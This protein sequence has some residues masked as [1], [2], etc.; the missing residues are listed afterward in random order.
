MNLGYLWSLVYACDMFSV[1]KDKGIHDKETGEKLRREVLE[2][3]AIY[4]GTQMPILVFQCSY[5]ARNGYAC[6]VSRTTARSARLFARRRGTALS[7]MGGASR[8]SLRI[9]EQISFVILRIMSTAPSC[10]GPLIRS[11]ANSD[12]GRTKDSPSHT[13]EICV[14]SK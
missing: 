13:L 4:P 12:R 2:P 11:N 7:C 14:C 6:K 8:S 5:Y 1:F 10:G 3:V 9:R